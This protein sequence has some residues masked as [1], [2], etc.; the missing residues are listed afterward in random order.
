MC[1]PGLPTVA[2]FRVGFVLRLITSMPK[3]VKNTLHS[4]PSMRAPLA[5][6]RPGYAPS[7]EPFEMMIDTFSMA[8]AM[9]TSLRQWR[10]QTQ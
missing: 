8:S 5:S 7:K 3:N 10:R 1:R 9:R 6:I 4:M 2:T